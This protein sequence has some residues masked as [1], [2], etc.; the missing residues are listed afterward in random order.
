MPAANGHLDIKRQTLPPSLR[1]HNVLRI[2]DES[3]EA[4]RDG[5]LLPITARGNDL[6]RRAEGENTYTCTEVWYDSEVH[7]FG[8]AVSISLPLKL[9]GNTMTLITKKYRSGLYGGLWVP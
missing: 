3:R 2:M 4:S 9:H 7:S 6:A 5:V 8:N 1:P